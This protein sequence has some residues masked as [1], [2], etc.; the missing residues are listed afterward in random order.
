MAGLPHFLH[1]FLT[2]VSQTEGMRLLGFALLAGLS[3]GASAGTIVK[4]D[5]EG[6]VTTPAVGSGTAS[7]VGFRRALRAARG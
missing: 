6:D 5:F 1:P 4:W 7:L 2:L 3:A